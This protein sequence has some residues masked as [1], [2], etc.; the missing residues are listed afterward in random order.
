MRS[1]V[2]QSYRRQAAR[3]YPQIVV[4]FPQAGCGYLFDLWITQ[5]IAVGKAEF[6]E[7]WPLR[8]LPSDRYFHCVETP[9]PAAMKPKPTTMF[10]LSRLS[11]GSD[12]SVT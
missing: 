2:W 7:P 8:P 6:T 4:S 10:Q 12:P 3:G 9:N 1:I 11:I 5:R